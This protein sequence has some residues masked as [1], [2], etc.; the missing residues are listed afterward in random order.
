MISIDASPAAFPRTVLAVIVSYKTSDLVKSLLASL[1]QERT[2]EAAHGIVLRA[3]VI[4]N[5]SGDDEPIRR[6][7][8]ESGGQDWIDVI[9]APRNGGFAY[10]NNLGFR[11]GFESAPVPD[12]FFLLNPDTEVRGG[13]VRVL[14]DFLDRHADAGIVGS[15]LELRD[16]TRWP[17][18]FR[19]PSLLGEVEH[20][21]RVGV[22]SKLLHRHIVARP[23]GDLS[24]QVDWFP[25]ASM[26][27]RRKVIEDVG[28]MDE[29][30]FLYYEETDFCLKVK[31]AGWTI[32][33]VPDSRVMHIAGQSTGVT[34]EQEGQRRL[35]PYWFES[36][37]RYFA[38]NHGLSYAMATDAALLL[39]SVVGQAK[40]RLKGRGRAGVPRFTRDLLHYSV[41]RKVNRTLAPAQEW[42]PAPN[43]K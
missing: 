39:A 10:G 38:K 21:L 16:G 43:T 23:M 28:G 26:M 19:Y 6:A 37:R 12:F 4:D 33:Y 34:G 18:A 20:G 3:V 7:I 30:Y 29:A 31:G 25:G 22:V 8:A 9:S 11:H 5:A 35:P 40:E 13:A 41:F 17:F 1:A 27:V 32:W 42:R 14:V 15:G 36:R 24:E 2:T